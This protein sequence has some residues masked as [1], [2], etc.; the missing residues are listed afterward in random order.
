MSRKRAKNRRATAAVARDLMLA[1]MVVALRLPL[2]SAEAGGSALGA[3]T[4]SI[5]AVSEKL[6]AFADGMAAAQLAFMRGAFMLPFAFAGARS[7]VDPL[8]DMAETVAAAAL[9]PAGLQVRRNH[10]RLLRPK[11]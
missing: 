3:R 1:P 5:G 10:R 9:K 6:A 4:E 11:A 2:M 8:L 7:P